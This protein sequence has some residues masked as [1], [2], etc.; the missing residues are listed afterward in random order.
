MCVCYVFVSSLDIWESSNQACPFISVFQKFLLLISS[1]IVPLLCVTSV[2]TCYSHFDIHLPFGLLVLHISMF[3]I[4][5]GILSE[6]VSMSSY[7][8]IY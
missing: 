2:L 3:K 6:N 5:S 1:Y 4:I 8:F 7:S